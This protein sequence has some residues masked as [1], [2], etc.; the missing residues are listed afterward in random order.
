MSTVVDGLV[1]AVQ[2][3]PK[4]EK[5][6]VINQLLADVDIRE[7]LA[8]ALV[9]KLLE[10]VG[11]AD[12]HRSLRVTNRAAHDITAR[13]RGKR[14]RESYAATLGTKGI[15]VNHIDGVWAKTPSLWLALPFATERKPNHWFLGLSEAELRERLD[16]EGAAVILLC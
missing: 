3:L 10:P 15:R 5:T 13:E 16:G 6:R 11:S 8:E 14:V 1:L 4:S 12:S 9:D 7:A 2:S